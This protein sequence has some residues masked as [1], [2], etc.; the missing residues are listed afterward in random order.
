M[1]ASLIVS[2]HLTIGVRS[3]EKIAPIARSS[4]DYTPRGE[5]GQNLG[6]IRRIDGQAG[7]LRHLGACIFADL[8]DPCKKVRPS[9]PEKGSHQHTLG[10]R[11]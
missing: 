4:F 5:T 11:T 3:A 8:C 1:L 7:N 6:L 2:H 10:S 9:L